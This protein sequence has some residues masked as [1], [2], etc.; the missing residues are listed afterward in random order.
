MQH[1]FSIVGLLMCSCYINAQET[2]NYRPFIEE[3][4]M[5]ISYEN[6]MICPFP[7]LCGQFVRRDYFDGDT[8]V[9]GQQCKRWIQQFTRLGEDKPAFIFIVPAYEENKRVWFFLEGE[10]TKKL[11]FDFGAS[12][13]DEFT[14]EPPDA[15]LWKVISHAEEEGSL[16]PEENAWKTLYQRPV[17]VYAKKDS[18]LEQRSYRMIGISGYTDNHAGKNWVLEGIGSCSRPDWIFEYSD[19]FHASQLIVC[20][21]NDEVLYY[22]NDAAKYYQIPLPTSLLSLS[23]ANGR[24]AQSDASHLM[25]SINGKYFDLTG[26]RLAAPPAKGVYIRDGKKMAR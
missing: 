1:F 10:T 4:K 20:T 25:K 18:V 8:L 23:K 24:T 17:H 9:D 7:E 21:I 12:V 19:A 5:W 3:G 6:N 13:G 14:I 16:A 2:N 15:L 11:M 22:D 26:R